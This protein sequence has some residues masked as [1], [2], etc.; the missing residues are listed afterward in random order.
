[1]TL[2]EIEAFLAVIKYGTISAASEK[3]FISQPALSR[4]IHAI[5]EEL[6]YGLFVR[7]KGV[8]GV[9]LTKEGQAFISVAEKMSGL[10]RE[11]AAIS[12]LSD[13]PLFR[14]S[15]IGS[16]STYLL[17]N[18]LRNLKE[19]TGCSL[20]FHNYHSLEAYEY[21]EKG[22]VDLALISD[23]IYSRNVATIPAFKEPFV[24]IGG[25]GLPLDGPVHPSQLQAED[26]IRLPWNPEYDAWH[27]KWFHP[28]VFPS[29]TLDQMSLLEYFLTGERWA[30]APLTVAQRIQGCSLKILP[31]SDGPQDHI[32]YYLVPHSAKTPVAEAFLRLLDQ[33]VTRISGVVSFL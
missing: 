1:M 27:D 2:S 19:V 26:E 13:R 8:R 29:V 9:E 32:V 6:G 5:E 10:Y 25:A 11:A 12:R 3:L 30:A 21:V 14:I 24:I 18:V 16:V 7:G 33:E 17:P 31:L 20:V 28:T 23:D 4:R 22:L 15:S